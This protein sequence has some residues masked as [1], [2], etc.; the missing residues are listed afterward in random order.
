MRGTEI[1]PAAACSSKRISLAFW[2]DADDVIDPP[3]RAKLEALMA[4]L[5]TRVAAGYVLRCAR[6]PSPDGTAAILWLTTSVGLSGLTSGCRSS[7]SGFSLTSER[8]SN[9]VSGRKA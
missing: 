8:H 6:D 1:N 4:S 3:E 7:R 2:L 5:T 9:R